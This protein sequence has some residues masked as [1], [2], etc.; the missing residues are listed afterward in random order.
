MVANF[1]TA[2]TWQW[3]FVSGFPTP[4]RRSCTQ[5]QSV[6][7]QGKVEIQPHRTEWELTKDQQLTS[8]P[9]KTCK[10]M[11]ISFSLLVILSLCTHYASYDAAFC[12][13]FSPYVHITP[14]TSLSLLVILSLCTHYASYDA[15]FCSLFSSYVHI[16]PVT[17]PLSARY[18][19]PM[20]TLRLLRPLSLLVI[21]SLC[22]HY[23]SY[24]SLSAP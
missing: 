22:T 7:R 2:H 12:S 1:W 15:A 19:L 5:R 8:F 24:L 9:P 10:T 16:T 14:V 17:T 6:C 23:A 3:K 4:R 11:R 20:Y 18:S 13:L 21:L